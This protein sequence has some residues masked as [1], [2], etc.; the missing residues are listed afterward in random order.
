[1]SWVLYRF[2]NRWATRD[3]SGACL[4]LIMMYAIH[5]FPL[6]VLFKVELSEVQNFADASVLLSVGKWILLCLQIW[7]YSIESSD[8]MMMKQI[9]S[10]FTVIF[11]SFSFFSIIRTTLFS[12]LHHYKTYDG[13]IVSLY[14]WFITF[15][16]VVLLP[17]LVVFYG[18]INLHLTAPLINTSLLG[19]F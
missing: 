10:D 18:V 3:N 7:A 8:G 11:H 17:L 15:C 19:I 13:G 4:R 14:I 5:G 1:M 12:R 6:H 9:W 16:T 2:I